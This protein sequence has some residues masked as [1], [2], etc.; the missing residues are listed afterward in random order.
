MSD[1]IDTDIPPANPTNEQSTLDLI[2]QEIRSLK[3]R[4]SIVENNQKAFLP[5]QA[6]KI[7]ELS[8]D[9]Q[10][11]EEQIKA[12]QDVVNKEHEEMTTVKNVVT[13]DHSAMKD[14]QS[15]LKSVEETE[16]AQKEEQQKV[17]SNLELLI[18]DEQ[19]L[20][21][22]EATAE[23][24]ISE[25]HNMIKMLEQKLTVELSNTRATMEIFNNNQKRLLDL[26]NDSNNNR[27]S[28]TTTE[29]QS[30]QPQISNSDSLNNDLNNLVGLNSEDIQTIKAYLP[31]VVL[32]PIYTG[33][34]TNKPPPM[35]D[36][37]II[38][39]HQD[40]QKITK[41]K[42]IQSYLQLLMVPYKLFGLF[43][44]PYLRGNYIDAIADQKNHPVDGKSF[45]YIDIILVFI[46]AS[47]LEFDNINN[48]HHMISITPT[49]GKPFED[50]VNRIRA[51]SRELKQYKNLF[52]SIRTQVLYYARK[53]FPDKIYNNDYLQKNES[54]FFT[55][56]NLI[57]G[58]AIVPS[59]NQFIL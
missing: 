59:Y 26:I 22:R 43:F 30:K 12:I 55:D 19:N 18:V 34:A 32:H 4:L 56:I 57:I 2:L 10:K 29:D 50:Y 6:R 24:G 33:N 16:F 11:E 54:T 27:F 17:Q 46:K 5:D 35:R 58:S 36:E 51:A 8:T 28:S 53:F 40:Q 45:S 20:K 48:F 25:L 47:H 9:Y 14:V 49:E 7:G 13:E 38:E 1:Q 41:F 3:D 39:G 23:T 44:E 52:I 21:Q 42:N 37:L 15:H 31:F